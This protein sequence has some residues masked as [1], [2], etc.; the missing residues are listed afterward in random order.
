MCSRNLCN[1]ASLTI[2]VEIWLLFPLGREANDVS[3]IR[4]RPR[5]AETLTLRRSCSA[6]VKFQEFGPLAACCSHCVFTLCH[7]AA[8]EAKIAQT[9]LCASSAKRASLVWRTRHFCHASIVKRPATKAEDGIR[10][11]I[12]TFFDVFFPRFF[13]NTHR[14][15]SPDAYPLIEQ[16]ITHAGNKKATK[17]RHERAQEKIHFCEE[18]RHKRT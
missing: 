16:K 14:S 8:G 2:P 12:G 10:D 4:R 15:V 18:K 6:G 5:R 7:T 11:K 1:E 9:P 13:D 3:G 17:E